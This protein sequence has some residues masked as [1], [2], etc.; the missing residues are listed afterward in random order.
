MLGAIGSCDSKGFDQYFGSSLY[1]LSLK[2]LIHKVNNDRYEHYR[3][4][5]SLHQVNSVDRLASCIL[6]PLLLAFCNRSRYHDS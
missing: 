6:A 1:F 4:L 2:S 3:Q 5:T